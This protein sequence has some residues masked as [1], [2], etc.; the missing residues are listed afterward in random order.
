MSNGLTDQDIAL[1]EF[2]ADKLYAVT[3]A[4][5]SACPGKD[6]ADLLQPLADNVVEFY[7]AGLNH[8]FYTANAGE[9]AWLDAGGAGGGWVRTGLAFRNGAPQRV[10]RFYG[11]LNPGPNSHFYTV[12]TTECD[13]LKELQTIIPATE[14][15]WNYEGLDFFS[16]PPI[17][18]DDRHCPEGTI[19][20]YRAYNNGFARGTDSNH[21]LTT[22]PQAIQEAVA[23]G[24]IDEGVMMCAGQ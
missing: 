9:Q 16:A 18:V 4:G 19:P 2:S 17:G 5:L 10:C 15:R 3:A 8:F 13:G 22:S 21:R 14:K 20:V 23:S 12:V 6:C 11:S 24:W 1:I 7:H